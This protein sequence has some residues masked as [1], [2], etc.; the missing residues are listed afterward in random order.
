MLG[1]LAPNRIIDFRRIAIDRQSVLEE[2]LFILQYVFRY[3][4]QVKIQVAPCGL[5][6]VDKRVE[7]P[8]FDVF[9]IRR[10]EVA[11]VYLA[12]HAAKTFFRVLQCPVRV[13]VVG[14]QIIRT[15]LLRIVSHVQN[16]Q[17]IALA[18]ALLPLREQLSRLDG[19]DIMIVQILFGFEML[20]T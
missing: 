14:I 2:L 9:D 15:T 7:H 19:T 6:V 4:T 17:R 10:L 16:R 5:A 3:L 12:H 13:N 11:L 20:R 18:H 8:E 1:Y